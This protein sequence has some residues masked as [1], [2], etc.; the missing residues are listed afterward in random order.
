MAEIFNWSIAA[1]S[2]NNAPPNGFPENMNYSDVNDAARE[3]MAV[4]ARWYQAS[5]GVLVTTGSSNAYVLTPDQTFVLADRDP[6]VS[7]TFRAHRTNTGSATLN[8]KN[9]GEAFIAD[10]SGTDVGSGGIQQGGAYTVVWDGTKWRLLGGVGG[11]GSGG[12]GV[13]TNAE[14]LGG[15]GQ[16]DDFFLNAANFTGTLATGVSVPASTLTGIITDARIPSLDASK[17]TSGTIDAS[18]LPSGSGGGGGISQTDADARYARLSAENIFV[19]AQQTLRTNSSR[20]DVTLAFQQGSSIRGRVMF[21]NANG[22]VLQNA[23]ANAAL[24]I[25]NSNFLRFF[26]STAE[27]FRVTNTGHGHFASDVTAYSSTALSDRRLKRDIEAQSLEEC[28]D[29]VNAL[30]PVT[31]EFNADQN[32]PGRFHGFVAQEVQEVLPR[33]VKES[34]GGLQP[35]GTLSIDS[36]ALISSLVG[37]VKALNERIAHLEEL[38]AV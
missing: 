22:M 19:G 32:R 27:R 30:R 4:M 13:G 6:G 31:F 8:V 9:T 37:A 35:D 7:F 29:V 14:T 5:S 23:R 36:M 25:D 34:E 21:D 12:G 3:V 15:A 1:N 2:N 11:S 24:R 16:D 20:G 33:A 38:L 18:L 26:V 28:L 10:A 17:I